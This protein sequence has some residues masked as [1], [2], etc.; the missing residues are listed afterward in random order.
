MRLRWAHTD[1]LIAEAMTRHSR[2][3]S[4]SIAACAVLLAV[5]VLL[6]VGAT[7]ASA[8]TVRVGYYENE[9]KVFT[10]GEGQPSGIFVDLIEEM[11]RAEDWDLV[12]V[13]GTFNE[14][15]E[16][17]EAGR[18]D[19]MPDV[20][21]TED[22]AERFD[23]HVT[24]V[25]ESWSYV[26]TRPGLRVDGIS[27]L[28]DKRVAVLSGSV[29]ERV[30]KQ[31]VDGFGLNVTLVPT[32]SLEEAFK[33]ASERQVDAAIANYLFGEYFHERYELAQSPIV[34][35]A[36]PLFYATDKGRNA[37]LRAAIDR[38]LV[39]WT[40][41]PKSVY[42]ATLSRYT[43]Q[44]G[45]AR[46]PEWLSWTLIAIVALLVLASG[47]IVLLRWQVGAR[48]RE[49]VEANDAV[50][51][52][53][54]TLRLAVDATCDG[55]FDWYPKTGEV[56]WT[57][58]SYT[59][60]GYEPDEIPVD[61]HAWSDLVHPEDRE[62]VVAEELD[63][64]RSGD[65]RF[66]VEYRLRRQDGSWMW[67][68]SR[69][70]V[71]RRDSEGD[72]ERV[73]GVNADITD[74]KLAELELAQY[75]DHLEQLVEQRTRELAD[76]NVELD[77]SNEALQS[78]NEELE[79]A[80]DDLTH[81]NRE[82]ARATEAKSRFLASMSHELR[83]PMNSIIGFSGLLYNG[84]VGPLT[85]EQ[86][87]QIGMVYKSGKQLLA[88]ISDVLDL[89]KVE[90]GKIEPHLATFDPGAVVADVA[91]TI[92][93]LAE[94]KHLELRVEAPET[95]IE[96]VSDEA[97]LRQILVNLAGNAVKFTESG[98]VVL[99]YAHADGRATFSVCDTG[100][101][102][103]DDELPH[104]F[105]SF[106]QGER[107]ETAQVKGTGLGLAISRDFA[108]LLG[109]GIDVTTEVGKGSVFTLWL[110]IAGPGAMSVADPVSA[111]G[112]ELEGEPS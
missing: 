77:M 102:I 108:R 104:V 2:R 72:P 3:G 34:F 31:M 24:P 23:F 73:M 60:L 95:S 71:A 109:G 44:E 70:K 8:R 6:L 50:R 51:S 39:A 103:D 67:T 33:L 25:V 48:T 40:G 85:E 53:E 15:L 52:A 32:S 92:Q 69:G 21:F 22:R 10:D 55:I 42:Y 63:A 38:H 19:L 68:Q 30:F 5:A 26:Y 75:R 4:R 99:R 45:R 27:E 13:H 112:V 76:A 11:A 83:T 90:A 12:W 84:K 65:G 88:L 87:F 94:E 41:E 59:M 86:R 16:S 89:A 66:A 82:L 1:R 28:R 61:F 111:G 106:R 110:P 57:P 78:A 37:D 56:L 29:Q 105:E 100:P 47:V 58:R 9:P 17:L 14:G 64:I 79:Q 18:I 97:R 35:N 93:P 49:L 81:V 91:Q 98:S 43:A 101:G 7:A 46:L 96:L 80:L 36:V 107:S 54:E 20:A 74:R 62:R